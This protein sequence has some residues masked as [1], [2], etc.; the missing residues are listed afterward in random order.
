M[1]WDFGKS[2]VY[3]SLDSMHRRLNRSLVTYKDEFAYCVAVGNSYKIALTTLDNIQQGVEPSK[4]KFNIST[5]ADD[6]LLNSVK[7]KLGFMNSKLSGE[8]YFI[9]RRGNRQQVQGLTSDNTKAEKVSKEGTNLFSE[10][11]FDPGMNNMLQGKYPSAK[12]ALETHKA[13]HPQ[14]AFRLD[15]RLGLT[16]LCHVHRP[17]GWVHGNKIVLTGPE[18]YQKYLKGVLHDLGVDIK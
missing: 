3:D 6:P 8:V 10:I 9:D 18:M 4:Q 11:I 12:E 2:E 17:V 14:F 15:N 1:E 13:F 7:L 16:E 5:H